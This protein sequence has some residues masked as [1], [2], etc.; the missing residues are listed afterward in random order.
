MSLF[1]DPLPDGSP[2]SDNKS[3]TI[4]PKDT[5]L[6]RKYKVSFLTTGG[7]GVIYSTTIPDGKY[8]IK[9]VDGTQ[10]KLVIALNQEKST[11]ERLDHEGIV[12]IYDFFEEEGYY[13]LVLEYVDGKTLTEL[14]P[15]SPDIYLTENT[16]TGW[17]IQICNILDYLHNLKPPLIYRDLKPD[18]IM[19]ENNTGN[20]KIIDFG[21]ARF[22]KEGK[23]T[24]G[25][26]GSVVTASP[27]HYGGGKTDARSD[28]YTL[29]A[30][31]HAVLTNGKGQCEELFIFHPLRSINKDVSPALEKVINKSLALE[32]EE[33]YQTVKEFRDALL[34]TQ[35]GFT[36]FRPPQ[37]ETPQDLKKKKE[38]IIT[39]RLG[40]KV[41]EEDKKK[42]G[43]I[44]TI[45]VLLVVL[46]IIIGFI[47]FI[48]YPRYQK[49]VPTSTPNVSTSIDYVHILPPDRE[50]VIYNRY[51]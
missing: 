2:G 1:R 48:V 26:F 17:A 34:Q 22:L 49:A 30:T 47:C 24:D 10:P 33:R 9:E 18:N 29:G 4:L 3:L 21:V 37:I 36:G 11:L 8:I 13:Y 38:Q 42:V 12:K 31:M 23:N 46:A 28:I 7:M 50:S 5:V 41:T 40:K 20:I 32:P 51:A 27:E 39:E 14:L 16:V 44:F 25:D 6:K 15:S 35:P 43:L 19:V 45:S